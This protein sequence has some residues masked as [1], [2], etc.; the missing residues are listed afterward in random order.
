MSK[1]YYPNNFDAI[2]SA[3]D[4]LFE[5]CTYE[6][7]FDWRLTAWQIPS[8][9]EC[10]I[11]AEHLETG[12]ITEHVYMKASAAKNRLIKYMQGGKHRVTVADH[13]FISLVGINVESE[14]D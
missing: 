13:E 2:A 5:S 12:K 9:I 10:I 7:F 6:E 8:S 14:P 1:S 4:E 11:R 3:P